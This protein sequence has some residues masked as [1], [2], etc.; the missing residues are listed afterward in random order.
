MSEKVVTY[1]VDFAPRTQDQL[2][3]IPRPIRKLIFDRIDKLRENPRPE[4]IEP[5]Q[6]SDKGLYHDLYVNSSIH[7]NSS[8]ALFDYMQPADYQFLKDFY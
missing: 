5:L 3:L 2:E 1:A 4:N 7:D 8:I 6:G